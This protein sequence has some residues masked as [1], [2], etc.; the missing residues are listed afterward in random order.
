MA[1]AGQTVV[2]LELPCHRGDEAW[3]LSASDLTKE[4][5]ALLVQQELL[6]PNDPVV[7]TDDHAVPFAYPILEVG[8]KDKA[9]R[10]QNYLSRFNNL[11]LL[12]RGAQ[13]RYTHVHTLYARAKA[14]ARDLAG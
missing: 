14:L 12:G 13:F 1:P 8:S 5:H 3:S 7:A 6:D 9:E 4:A 2:V 11:H 10:L